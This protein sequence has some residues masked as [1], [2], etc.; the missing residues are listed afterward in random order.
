MGLV[1]VVCDFRTLQAIGIIHNVKEVKLLAKFG[2]F[3]DLVRCTWCKA[4]S[5]AE[6]AEYFISTDFFNGFLHAFEVS[7]E[8]FSFNCRLDDEWLQISCQNAL[9]ASLLIDARPHDIFR[10]WLHRF[11]SKQAQCDRHTCCKWQHYAII[12][13][14]QPNHLL[15]HIECHSLDQFYHQA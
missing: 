15:Q 14:A 8:T 11:Q 7:D 6:D 10:A 2:D 12:D 4:A 13:T 9:E 3:D 5:R 1:E